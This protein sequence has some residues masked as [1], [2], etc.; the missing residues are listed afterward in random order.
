M[1]FYKIDI[2]TASLRLIIKNIH[3]L[4]VQMYEKCIQTIFNYVFCG[5]PCNYILRGIVCD[6]CRIQMASLPNEFF[7]DRP[8]FKVQTNTLHNK[9]FIH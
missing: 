1:S 8:N 2:Y 3:T 4:Y 6:K 5:A 9:S 7:D